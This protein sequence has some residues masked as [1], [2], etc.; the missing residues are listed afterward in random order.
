MICKNCGK[1]I[2]DGVSFCPHCGKPVNNKSENI[3]KGNIDIIPDK[4][5]KSWK[6][7]ALIGGVGVLVVL[8]VVVSVSAL[9]S[10]KAEPNIQANV[11]SDKTIY[12][13]KNDETLGEKVSTVDSE[14]PPETSEP[15]EKKLT[16]DDYLQMSDRELLDKT[17]LMADANLFG[18]QWTYDYNLVIGVIVKENVELGIT[19][20]NEVYT[21][22]V[23]YLPCTAV[24][25]KTKFGTDTA[26]VEAVSY[27]GG[28][29]PD[30]MNF[31][32]IYKNPV[33]LDNFVDMPNLKLVIIPS[34]YKI[35]GLHAFDFDD[36][37]E[38]HLER[39]VLDNGIET[40]ESY[41]FHNCKKL[42]QINLPE[43]LRAI[44]YGAFLNC[45]S[46][47]EVVLPRKIEEISED[48]FPD[49]TFFHVYKNTYAEQWCI[50]NNRKYDYET[51]PSVTGLNE[52]SDWQKAYIEFLNDNEISNL[53][54]AYIDEDDIPE[55]T[56]SYGGCP[57]LLTYCNG[58]INR[59]DFPRG[60]LYYFEKENKF[61]FS[62]DLGNFN[63][64]VY[65]LD[66][67]KLK[68]I[69]R[70]ICEQKVDNDGDPVEDDQGVIVFEYYW[71]N[72][73]VSKEEYLS[74]LKK[75]FDS[76]SAK[77][78]SESN[79]SSSQEMIETISEIT[80]SSSGQIS[81]K[82]NG[83]DQDYILPDCDSRYYSQEELEALSAEQLKLARN[84]IYARHGYIFKTDNT[85]N[86]FNSKSWY[87]GTVT[88][89]TDDMLNEYEIA[90]RDLIILIEKK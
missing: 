87:R 47:S 23:L 22:E 52:L 33:D 62:S 58:E 27:G 8:A 32:G 16:I 4:S 1:Q 13:E 40:I 84:E 24:D 57:R 18:Y 88:E 66:N 64:T 39:V 14:E 63:D 89:V 73:L 37:V 45:K 42:S 38:S 10:D 53:S 77:Y 11:A 67:G 6:I 55:I 29:D 72:E 31:K 80:G 48:S 76:S 21:A 26:L 50:E 78:I 43:S 35:I 2:K 5:I 59:E 56:W 82:N 61:M 17:S 9:K 75:V 83:Q 25:I 79:G 49:E 34:S 44:K 86:Y 81:S 71:N 85:K 30:S 46:L 3:S 15:K 70:G 28:S 20:D 69:I 68:E 19:S 51:V 41:A 7:P 90:N 12:N 36:E 65:E 74:Q 60:E 54:L